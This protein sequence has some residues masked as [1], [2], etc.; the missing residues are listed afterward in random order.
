MTASAS[1]ASPAARRMTSLSKALRRQP[2]VMIST[3]GHRQPAEQAR[4]RTLPSK[5]SVAGPVI[6][7]W[8]VLAPLDVELAAVERSPSRCRPVSPRRCAATSAAQAPLPQARVMPGAALPDA[9]PDAL[10]VARPRR[11]RYWRARE[12]A[13]HAR[14]PGRA[15]RGRSPRHRRRRTSR[16]GCPYWCRPG[17]DSGP[18]DSSTC[19]VS[20]SPGQRDVAPVGARPAPC[21]PR[22]ARPAASRRRAARPRSRCAIRRLAGFAGDQPGDA[23]GA[24]CRRP[25]PRCRRR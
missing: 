19:S 1:P 25:R 21:R 23:A 14:A 13:R 5:P 17:R 16:A 2:K 4:R 3:A 8:P 18:A 15:S 22:R 7:T 20:I 10:A 12:T 11:R 24:R 6:T 9:Q